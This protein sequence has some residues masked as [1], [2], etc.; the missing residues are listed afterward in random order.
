MDQKSCWSTLLV[1]FSINVGPI[2]QQN[3]TYNTAVTGDTEIAHNILLMLQGGV[4]LVG[5]IYM[6]HTMS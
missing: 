3:A 2:Q 4:H 1:R 5:F 6:F